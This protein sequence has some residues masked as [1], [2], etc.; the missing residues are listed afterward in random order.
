[1]T[2]EYSK[3]VFI[4]Y[5]QIVFEKM[6]LNWDEDNEYEIRQAVDCIFNDEDE[7]E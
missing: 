5:F 3:E 2:R 1:M 6:G 7:E 4:H